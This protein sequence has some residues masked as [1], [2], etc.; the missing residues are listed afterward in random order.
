MTVS[1]CW[2]PVGLG[3]WDQSSAGSPCHQGKPVT[4]AAVMFMTQ[5]VLA[6]CALH[7]DLV[8]F[9]EDLVEKSSLNGTKHS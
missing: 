6:L 1:T 4:Q 8:A 2:C 5:S 3:S 9:A 7:N